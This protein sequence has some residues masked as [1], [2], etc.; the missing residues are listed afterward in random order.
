[1]NP[2]TVCTALVNALSGITTLRRYDTVP[3]DPHP[4]CVIA[5]PES[6]DYTHAFDGASGTYVLRV[7][8][9][10]TVAQGGQQ[11]MWNYLATSG[12]SSIPA[13][14]HGTTLS[15][16]VSGALITE[17]RNHGTFQPSGSDIR[18]YSAELVVDIIS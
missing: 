4:P 15:G 12:A 1:M 6:I 3:D 2:G 18:Y 5:F 17:S 10:S 13:L 7:L 11:A 8:G 16:A 9:P 14:I